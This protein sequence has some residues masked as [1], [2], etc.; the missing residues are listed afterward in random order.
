MED[1]GVMKEK[2]IMIGRDFS[3]IPTGRTRNDGPFSGESFRE[4]VLIPALTENDHV[5]VDLAGVEGVGSSF[6]EEVF[7]GLVR[8]GKFSEMDLRSKLQIITTDP[9]FTMCIPKIIQYMDDAKQSL[10]LSKTNVGG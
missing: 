2:I 7:G 8:C 4:D 9:L 10:M 3:T 1:Q 5:I 6:L